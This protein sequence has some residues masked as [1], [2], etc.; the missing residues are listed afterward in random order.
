[1]THRL[2]GRGASKS[3]FEPSFQEIEAMTKALFTPDA[4]HF[5]QDLRR[6]GNK[7]L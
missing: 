6:F 3:V 5:D 2:S 7:Q 4:M 1:M